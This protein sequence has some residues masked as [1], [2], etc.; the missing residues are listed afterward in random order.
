M[1]GSTETG[2]LTT[3]DRI[4]R[5][6]DPTF[7][8]PWASGR[9]RRSRW[10]WMQLSRRH[11]DCSVGQTSFSDLLRLC[12]I[13]G[14]SRRCR[15]AMIF[16]RR[17]RAAA[18]LRRDNRATPMSAAA[19]LTADTRCRPAY[20]AVL[21]LR[22]HFRERRTSMRR[23]PDYAIQRPERGTTASHA[24]CRLDLWLVTASVGNQP[25]NL[26]APRHCFGC[27]RRRRTSP[28]PRRASPPSTGFPAVAAAS[29]TTRQPSSTSPLLY[30][31]TPFTATT[32]SC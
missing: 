23:T 27:D 18:M 32:T 1:N 22:F 19:R 30:P 3:K 5:G 6:R 29:G 8:A 12:N 2:I 20:H 28:R 13:A 26:Q 7:W 11:G 10:R 16:A 31:S 14:S 4:G 21:M 17:W 24:Y 15:L 25:H 9:L